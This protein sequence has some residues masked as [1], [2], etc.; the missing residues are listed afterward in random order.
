VV[1][2]MFQNLDSDPQTLSASPVGDSEVGSWTL[3][4]SSPRRSAVHRTSNRLGF[5]QK[6]GA[7]RCFR[8]SAGTG[9]FRVSL[10]VA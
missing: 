4:G 1:A 7:F 2:F 10:V 5:S 8:A 3:S 6:P 9:L